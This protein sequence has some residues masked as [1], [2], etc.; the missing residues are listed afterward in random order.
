MPPV[1]E[2]IIARFGWRVSFLSMGVFFLVTLLIASSYL[3][4]P[5]ELS[6]TP[7]GWNEM[8]HEER[9]RVM[10]F[11]F[12]ETLSTARSWMIYAMFLLCTFGS[13]LFIIHAAPFGKTHG[14]DPVTAA[15]ALGVLGAGSLASR[16]IFGVI[17]DRI[18][19]TITLVLALFSE[20]LGLAAL[21]FIGGSVSLFLACAFAIG[22]G[23]GGYL[24]DIIA[25]IGDLFGTRSIGSNLGMIETGFGIGGLIGPIA[26]G[27]YFSQFQNYTGILQISAF[28]VVIAI[29]IS[30]L[31]ARQ[32][33]NI[34]KYS[35]VN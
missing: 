18:P 7:Y 13:A 26:R 22:L 2:F 24:T 6:V 8:S 23:Y 25:L 14:L 12:R 16:V 20:L 3:R 4:S 30:F 17:S 19:R 5:E 29:V 27:A 1:A 10:D 21:P 34:E 15:L 32:V 9:G 33:R 35:T 31:F 11:T 28:L